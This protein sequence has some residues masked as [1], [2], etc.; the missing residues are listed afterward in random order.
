VTVTEGPYANISQRRGG[1]RKPLSQ[2]RA[3]HDREGQAGSVR[4][5]RSTP[6]SEF[7]TD[8]KLRHLDIYLQMKPI[9][10]ELLKSIV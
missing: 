5:G 9:P 8:G 6:G 7:N 4:G 10:A 2:W 1:R 3:G